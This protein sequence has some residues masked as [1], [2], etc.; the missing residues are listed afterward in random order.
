MSCA[1][2]RILPKNELLKTTDTIVVNRY[3]HKLDTIFVYKES[4]LYFNS[5]SLVTYR[6]DSIFVFNHS[7]DTTD[8]TDYKAQSKTIQEKSR[9]QQLGFLDQVLIASAVF[10]VAL[11]LSLLLLV[12]AAQR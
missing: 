1:G 6:H 4:V 5:D 8:K 2:S 12:I 3:T 7:S 9:K 10:I 11:V